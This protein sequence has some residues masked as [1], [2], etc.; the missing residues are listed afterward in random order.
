[1]KKLIALLITVVLW[2]TPK[3]NNLS[4]PL[5]VNVNILLD[6]ITVYN[7]T[8]RDSVLAV[9]IAY[10]EAGSEPCRGQGAIINSVRDKM[11][12]KR[13]SF[14]EVL[15]QCQYDGYR[16]KNFQ[17]QHQEEKLIEAAMLALK[18]YRFVPV[19]VE[20]FLNP[21][22][23]TDTVWMNRIEPHLYEKIANHCFYWH[24][25]KSPVRG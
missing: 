1:M 7:Y 2:H 4:F 13:L 14:E 6:E 19:G 20:Y 18:G 15:Q 11:V 16:S 25:E 12:R 22:E 8:S 9:R 5:R 21:E 10:A 24:P 23:S 17:Y 3:G